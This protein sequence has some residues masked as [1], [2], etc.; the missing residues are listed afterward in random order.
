MILGKS[1][2]QTAAKGQQVIYDKE[3]LSNKR[4][5]L[6]EQKVLKKREKQ[7]NKQTKQTKNH[8]LLLL[9]Y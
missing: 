4:P 9:Y 5:I 1:H 3:F 2:D 6:K 7:T 8:S